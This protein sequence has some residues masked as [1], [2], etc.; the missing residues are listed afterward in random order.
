MDT[1]RISAGSDGNREREGH[2]TG[3]Q[4]FIDVELGGAGEVQQRARITPRFLGMAALSAPKQTLPAPIM[5]PRRAASNPMESVSKSVETAPEITKRR[6]PT[7]S[8]IRDERSRDVIRT[9][10]AFRERTRKACAIGATTMR[11]RHM[12][13]KE[14]TSGVRQYS[15][16]RGR[17]DGSTVAPPPPPPPT[18]KARLSD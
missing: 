5:T 17:D 4:I 8:A 11:L 9:L 15:S 10:M 12:N 2:R 18:A 7:A 1:N 3:H 14:E 16:D 13:T 6:T